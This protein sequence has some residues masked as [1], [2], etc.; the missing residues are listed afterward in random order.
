MEPLPP[1][2]PEP[3][4]PDVFRVPGSGLNI[5]IIMGGLILIPIVILLA[6]FMSK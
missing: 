4:E 1:P 6:Y 5:W 3:P 2:I